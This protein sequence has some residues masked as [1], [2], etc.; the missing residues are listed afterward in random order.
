MAYKAFIHTRMNDY[1]HICI[2]ICMLTYECMYC[3]YI[4]IFINVCNLFVR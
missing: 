3:I 1:M 4:C 2:N